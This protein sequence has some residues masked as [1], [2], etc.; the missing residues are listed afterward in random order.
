MLIVVSDLILGAP[1]GLRGEKK[2]V[3]NPLKNH[4]LNSIFNQWYVE[5]D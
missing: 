5:I 3:I 2:L 4:S 1:S